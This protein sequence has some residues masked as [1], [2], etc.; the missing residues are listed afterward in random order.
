MIKVL[1][2]ASLATAL[3]FAGSAF[4]QTEPTSGSGNGAGEKRGSD[5][6]DMQKLE[7]KYW[8]AKDTDF[9]VVQNRTYSKSGRFFASLGY[10]PLVNDAY[11][12][13][14]MTGFSGGYY[15]SERMGVELAYES[16]SL[17]DNDSTTAF[18]TLANANASPDYNIFKSYTSA[19]FVIVP[20][21][22]KMSFWDRKI[23]YFDMQFS[24]GAG[25]M[26]YT[27]MIDDRNGGSLNG[28]ATGYNFDIT[29]Q[30]FF[31]ENMAFRFDIKNKWSK[32]KLYKSY[33]GAAATSATS[34]G[35]TNQ[36]DT[37][38]LFGVTFWL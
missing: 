36:Q 3:T 35:D 28:T 19:N 21:Y 22:A 29:Q 5:K 10:G 20:F 33:S 23:M 12:F 1:I 2:V 30:L 6:L 26:K 16:G 27:S 37:T 9:N 25:Q 4:A 17:K 11:S 15:F 24:V 31:H 32:Q 34:L 14:R 7:D 8:S 38:I 13:G 18:K